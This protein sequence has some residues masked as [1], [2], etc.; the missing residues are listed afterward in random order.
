MKFI[1]A[2]Y[3]VPCLHRHQYTNACQNRIKKKK[4]NVTQQI[5]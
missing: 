4:Q 2:L 3:D 5:H 1:L